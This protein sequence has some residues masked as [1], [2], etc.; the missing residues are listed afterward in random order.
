MAHCQGRLAGTSIVA[1][2]RPGAALSVIPARRALGRA[3][4]FA[5]AVATFFAPRLD[6]L[7][8]L[9]DSATL[10]CRCEDVTAGQ[11]CEFLKTHPH[12]SSVNSVK[13]ACRSGMGP[14][15]GRYC[16]HTIAHL[17]SAERNIAV[18]QTGAYTAQAPVKPIPLA[19]LALALARQD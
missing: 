4:P 8:K 9:A 11:A 6:A 15:Q 18:H 1:A 12:V 16:Q 13:L 17:V 7:T 3:K 19:S 5:D 10:I 2:L 14:C